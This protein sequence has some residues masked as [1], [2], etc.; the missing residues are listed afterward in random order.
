MTTSTSRCDRL[1]TAALVAFVL[2]AHVL[3]PIRTSFDSRWAIHTAVSLAYRGDGDLDEYDRLL[4]ADEDYGIE[5]RDGRRYSRYPIGPSLM[6]VPI[7]LAYDAVASLVSQPT[8]EDLIAQRRAVALEVVVASL[9]AGDLRSARVPEE[10]EVWDEDT[11]GGRAADHGAVGGG[12]AVGT[13]EVE[14]RTTMP[15]KKAAVE[16]EESTGNVFADLG[17]PDADA[18]QTKSE[19]VRL[20]YLAIKSRGWSASKAARVLGTDRARVS[21]LMNGRLA[22]FSIERLAR[23]LTRLNHDVVITVTAKKRPGRIRVAA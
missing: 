4:R 2:V 13:S 15:R 7:I 22:G 20:L 5:Q 6:A 11:E 12:G 1:V 8:A 9:V 14:G 19:L 10:V 21:S 23:L 18:L 3:S 17:L 16:F